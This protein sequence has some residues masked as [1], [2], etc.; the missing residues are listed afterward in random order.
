MGGWGDEWAA[1]KAGS[2]EPSSAVTAKREKGGGA[3]NNL[4]GWGDGKS[5]QIAMID[6]S[7]E[8]PQCCISMVA[9]FGD[10]HSS[11]CKTEKEKDRDR[12]K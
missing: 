10:F 8:N 5:S 7:P 12:A 11:F 1:G 2:E 4:G 3:Q 9:R 6:S